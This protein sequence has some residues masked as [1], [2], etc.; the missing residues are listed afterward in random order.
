V[1][2]LTAS[3]VSLKTERTLRLFQADAYLSADLHAKKLKVYR[4]R[5]P[6]GGGGGG[7]EGGVEEKIGG[8]EGAGPEWERR[9]LV[10]CS[11]RAPTAHGRPPEVTGKEGMR[12][13]ATAIEIVD[14]VE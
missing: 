7:A 11:L 12:A 14:L 8:E 9:Q 4:M 5:S 6:A 13:L 2:N 3:R 1:A 10:S